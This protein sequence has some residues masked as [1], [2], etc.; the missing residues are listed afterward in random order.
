MTMKRTMAAGLALLAGVLL[1]GGWAQALINPNFTPIHLVSQSDSILEVQFGPAK[2]GL[3]PATVKTVIKGKPAAKTISL[4]LASTAVKEQAQAV[5]KLIAESG[6]TPA[7]FFSGKINEKGAAPGADAGDAGETEKGFLHIN[8]QWISFDKDKGDVWLMNEISSPMLATWNG[9]DDMLRKV[10]DYILTDPDAVIPCAEGV[11]W[12]TPQ[13]FATIAGKV[14]VALPVTMVDG[15]SQVLFVA[16]SSGDRLFECDAKDSKNPGPKDVTAAHKLTTKSVV[17]TWGDLNADGRMDLVSWNGETVSV[18]LQDANG[19]LQAG[20]TL[21]TTELKGGCTSLAVI[22]SGV[23]GHP[24]VLIGT[25]T[26]PL[27]WTPSLG[28][29]AQTARP[30][31]AGGAPVKELG[32]AGRCLVADFDADGLADILQLFTKGSL[33]YKGK[34]PGQ[35]EAPKPCA[36]ALGTGP[37]DAFLGDFDADGLLDVV[38]LGDATQLW[39]NRGKME[40]VNVMQATG[41]LMYKGNTD[42]HFGAMGDINGDG[43]QDVICFYVNDTPHINFNRGFRSFGH[44]N[45]IDFK[46]TNVIP[47]MENGQQTGCW[48]DLNGDGIQELVIILTN[49][50]AWFLPVDN[51]SEKGGCVRVLLSSKSSYVGPVNV[52]GYR[53]KRCLCAWNV[54]PGTSEGFIAQTEAGPVTIKWQLPGG[55][56]QSKDIPIEN[57]PVRFLLP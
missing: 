7:L 31:T 2:G 44:A 4:N 47:G 26:M 19:A 27:L 51:G 43:R 18:L 34:A 22:D 9:G 38:T 21:P 37:S 13:K 5:E 56:P 54:L 29:E 10:V 50:E 16:A 49:G 52:V 32:A 36:V 40:F 28:A 25:A 20:A 1:P 46:T 23:A 48:T 11:Q 33:I 30:V 3:I 8:G 17:A 15:G 14:R 55:K 6:A 39:N 24:A 53:G 41:E 35:F 57:A 42:S 45:A 12:G